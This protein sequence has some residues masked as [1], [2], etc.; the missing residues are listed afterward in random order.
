M[1]PH[2]PL[3]D[4]YVRLTSDVVASLSTAFPQPTWP[5][6]TTP[7]AIA[8]ARMAW[9]PVPGHLDKIKGVLAEFGEA[10]VRITTN[11]DLTDQARNRT[12]AET[13]EAAR[14]QV[15]ALAATAL[16]GA[17]KS[18][19]LL[20]AAAYPPR[21]QPHDA[22]Q[23]A[24][25]AGIKSDARMTL[26]A[27]SMPSQIF[28]ELERLLHRAVADSNE[29]AAWVFASTTWPED[30]LRSRGAIELIDTWAS[31]VDDSLRTVTEGPLG[32]T[33]RA[34]RI[35]S[36]PKEGIPVLRLLFAATLPQV[37]DTVATWRPT[38][39]STVPPTRGLI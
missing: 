21:P 26:D 6:D 7:Q 5:T 18:L 8:R 1:K 12:L 32:Q 9:A 30:Y 2:N 20:R 22:A 29:L 34:Y 17:E 10:V 15:N 19:D 39:Y 3:L 36:D 28:G 38:S 23:E 31:T 24:S 16:T 25:I 37:I 14:T 11:T 13:A 33:R 35:A 4:V 27:A